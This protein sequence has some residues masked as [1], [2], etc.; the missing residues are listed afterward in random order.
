[1]HALSAVV[2]RW[3]LALVLIA[4]LVLTPP[5]AQA[6]DV[7]QGSRVAVAPVSSLSGKSDRFTERISDAI[8]S[9]LAELALVPTGAGDIQKQTRAKKYSHLQNCG[10]DNACLKELGE[11][12]NTEYVVYAEVGGLG[13]AT[14]VYLKVVETANAKELRSTTMEV[15]PE[16]DVSTESKAAAVRLFYP[17]RYVGYLDVKTSVKGASV[18]L[19][20]HKVASTPSKPIAVFV[21]SHALRV[22]HPEHQDYVRWVDIAFGASEV[23][24]ANLRT[25]P[26]VNKEMRLEGVIDDRRA[27]IEY[28]ER[29]WYFRWYTIAG[30]VAAVALT[31]AVIVGVSNG[32]IDADLV[33]DL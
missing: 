23:V 25:L 15:G 4:G 14:V 17:K 6:K 19:D 5:S 10:G 7:A 28:R 1:M 21:G 22:T 13:D 33:R 11:L 29:P 30:G 9:G 18:F 16:T 31:S 20:G 27:P 8:E 12:A 26:G 3:C 24:E 2:A 32:G